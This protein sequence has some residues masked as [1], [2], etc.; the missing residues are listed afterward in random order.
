MSVVY[1]LLGYARPELQPHA[2]TATV[3]TS[4][5]KLHAELLHAAKASEGHRGRRA[6]CRG[7]PC[8]KASNASVKLLPGEAEVLR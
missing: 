4:N 6:V 7:E 3:R 1:C 8:F 5:V 2:R